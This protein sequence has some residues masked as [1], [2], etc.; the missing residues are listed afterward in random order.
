MNADIAERVTTPL[1]LNNGSGDPG[2]PVL[3]PSAAIHSI[4]LKN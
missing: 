4:S 3:M 1:G 2:V